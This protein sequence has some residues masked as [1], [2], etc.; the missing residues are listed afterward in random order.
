[1]NQIFNYLPSGKNVFA[2][3]GEIH[4]A[5]CQ[6]LSDVE[7]NHPKEYNFIKTAHEIKELLHRI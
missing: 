4:A 1:M 5:A 7:I 3:G 2:A 6:L